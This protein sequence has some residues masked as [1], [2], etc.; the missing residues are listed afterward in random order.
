MTTPA[1]FPNQQY[2]LTSLMN[3][4]NNNNRQIENLQN[5][6]NEIR[7]D[8]TNLL[9]RYNNNNN[10]NNNN[11]R[12]RNS[13]LRNQNLINRNNII[14][15]RIIYNDSNIPNSNLSS[16]FNSI[17]QNFLDPVQIFPTQIQIENATRIVRF[18][19]IVR[20]INN[21]CPITLDNFGD[22]N[23]VSVIRHCN[24]IFNTDALNNWFRSNC[25]CPVCRYDIRIYNTPNTNTTLNT[26][27]PNTNTPNIPNISNIQYDNDNGS[28]TF[29]INS[30]EFYNNIAQ[31]AMNRFNNLYNIDASGNNIS[32][33]SGNNTQR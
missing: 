29:D 4:Y 7:N 33:A 26:N 6:N 24:H 19:D 5:A 12:Q 18:A 14:N 32:D 15:D 1:N 8:I 9:M 13:N 11:N 25:R 16:T 22:N 3:M 27:T 23:S 10:N 17:F 31:L 2:L 20:P 30:E 28:V 21:S